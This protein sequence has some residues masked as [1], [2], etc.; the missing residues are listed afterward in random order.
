MTEYTFGQMPGQYRC[1]SIEIDVD[2]LTLNVAGNP[3][4]LEPKTF[5]VLEFLLASQGRV[6]PK[7]AILAAVWA[8]TFVTDNVLTRAIAQIRK[9]VNDDPKAPAFIETVPT[10]GYRLVAKIERVEPRGATAPVTPRATTVVAVLPIANE[11]GNGELDYVAGG[12]TDATIRLLSKL[13]PLTVMARSTVSGFD[14]GREDACAFARRL[15]VE[16]V[17]V[18]RLVIRAGRPVLHA[19]L[20]RAADGAAVF[21]SEYLSNPAESM[22][23]QA[24]FL[25]DI[26][27]GLQLD[28][29]DRSSGIYSRPTDSAAAYERFLSASHLARR[30][31]PPDLFRAVEEFD[32]ALV[33][34]ANF[35]LAWAGKAQ[36][37]LMLAIH[38]DAPST[39]MPA[40]R[41][42]AERALTTDPALIEPH[43]VL[44]LVSLLF[45]WDAAGAEAHLHSTHANRHA[46]LSLSCMAHLLHQSGRGRN[47]EEQLRD[48][49]AYDPRNS[50]LVAELGC[51]EYYRG[52]FSEALE[53]YANA[54]ALDSLSP[55]VAW[56]TGKSLAQLGRFDDAI[57]VLRGFKTRAGFEPPVLTAELGFTY[58]LA[59]RSAEADDVVASLIAARQTSFVDPYL[60]ALVFHGMHDER[61]FEWLDRAFDEKSPFLISIPSEPKWSAA[62][63]EPRVQSLLRRMG[64]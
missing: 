41:A 23:V 34:D 44:G 19:E 60:I 33:L 22:D 21:S 47:A 3:Q 51:N 14:P 63:P 38:F 62:L 37:H 36:A 45:D 48:V 30:A 56:G 28:G 39:H 27:K 1:G 46:V 57:D 61:V 4:P 50:S 35:G 8:D 5:R 25:R 18:G 12:L 52:R 29:W 32:R 24:D 64:V 2:N 55:L 15:G 58:A 26:V 11:T 49:L 54:A 17:A 43:G 6:A 42:A 16:A 40:A 7:A 9:A 20:I 10:V 59:G 53:H 31:A 13:V